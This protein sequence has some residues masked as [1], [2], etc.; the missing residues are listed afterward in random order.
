MTR[1][2][3]DLWDDHGENCKVL[4]PI[5]RDFGKPLQF[6]GPIRTLKV[7]EDNSLVRKALEEKSNGEI[8]VVDGGGSTRCALLGDRLATLGRDNGW[9]GIVVFGAVRDSA[10]LKNIEFGVKAL[11]TNPKKSL[12][13]QEGQR[14]I[15]VCFAGV[16]ISPGD[17]L[18][19]DEDGILH[20]AKALL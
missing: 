11:G 6:Y 18:Y 1:S 2:T 8:L 10:V 4:E 3:A 17:Y 20:S 7:H 14:D 9:V 13:R 16:E 5:F 19:C 15:P 12:K